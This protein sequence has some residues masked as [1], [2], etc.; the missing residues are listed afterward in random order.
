MIERISSITIGKS[1]FLVRYHLPRWPVAGNKCFASRLPFFVVA[2]LLGS[3]LCHRHVL[4]IHSSYEIKMQTHLRHFY[5][6]SLI[7]SASRRVRYGS[8]TVSCTSAPG[9]ESEN[10]IVSPSSTESSDTCLFYEASEIRSLLL[11]MWETIVLHGAG[12]NAFFYPSRSDGR[13]GSLHLGKTKARRWWIH[14]FEKKQR[15]LGW[16]QSH[17]WWVT[18]FFDS[19]YLLTAR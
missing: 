14:I 16:I 12:G 13:I 18:L 6:L 11:A 19:Q 2:L 7:S 10:I 4:F 8:V 3:W 17:L 5:L 9:S 15:R 1:T